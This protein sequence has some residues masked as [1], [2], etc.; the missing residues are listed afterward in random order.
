MITEESKINNSTISKAL[1]RMK[2]KKEYSSIQSDKS[3]SSN[4]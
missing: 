4:K 2:N 1:E 3:F